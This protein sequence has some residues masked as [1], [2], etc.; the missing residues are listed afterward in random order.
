LSLRWVH[1]ESVHA[2]PG[3]AERQAG[4]VRLP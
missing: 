4:C 2:T 1:T 3:L